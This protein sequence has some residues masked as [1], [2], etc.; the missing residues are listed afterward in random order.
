MSPGSSSAP[1][2]QAH[3]LDAA[4]ADAD[5]NAGAGSV[6]DPVAPCHGGHQ[7]SSSG[8]FPS[9]T[10][11]SPSSAAAAQSSAGSISQS[12]AGS[13]SQSSLGSSSQSSLGSSSQSSL[14]SS[15]QSSSGAPSSSS[16]FSSS[17]SSRSSSS[18]GSSS[19]SSGR[20]ASLW[21][22][23]ALPEDQAKAETGSLR[24]NGSS[25]Y[26][27]TLGISA[28]FRANVDHNT[29]DV[30]FENVPTTAR[31]SLTY[32]GSDGTETIVVKDTP[33][34]NLQDDTP[35]AGNSSAPTGAQ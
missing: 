6:G 10:P 18:I 33:F 22:R 2:S 20:L 32:I 24:L 30:R 15:S 14:G 19:S 21:I 17:S 29:V 31:Y 11:S 16:G 5:A 28:S 34:Q 23:I 1:N 12:S 9:S 4:A 26:N 35:P 8:A 27:K 3:A 25:G 7:A 13:S